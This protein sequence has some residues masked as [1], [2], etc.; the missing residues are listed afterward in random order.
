MNKTLVVIYLT[1]ILDATGIGIIFPVL[2]SLLRE[3][4]HTDSMA[5]YIGLLSTAF[6][7]MQFVFAPM[8]GALSDRVWRRPVLLLALGGAAINYLFLCISPTFALL[9]IGR[10]IAGIT[11]ASLSVAMACLTDI[12]PPGQC[13]RRFGLFNAMFG[14]G[15]II[16]PV[17]GGLL[18]DYGV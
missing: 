11:G 3:V 2:P 1:V 8:L 18:S 4:M 6:A 17:L 16:G 7:V 14:V 5:F 10:A 15:F 13:A 9:L 12:S